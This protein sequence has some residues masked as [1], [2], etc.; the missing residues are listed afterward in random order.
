MFGSGSDRF[1]TTDA[2][3]WSL[4]PISEPS[5]RFNDHRQPVIVFRLAH[6]FDRWIRHCRR[7]SRLKNSLAGP[8]SLRGGRK[9]IGYIPILVDRDVMVYALKAAYGRK[10]AHIGSGPGEAE[11]FREDMVLFW[12]RVLRSDVQATA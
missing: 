2:C 5:R 11:L 4:L 9:T 8:P 3:N 6:Y 12:Q 7:I 1:D 10:G